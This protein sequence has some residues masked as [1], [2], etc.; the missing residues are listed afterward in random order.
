MQIHTVDEH[1]EPPPG[2]DYAQIKVRFLISMTQKLD[3]L[4]APDDVQALKG[5]LQ[6][7]QASQGQTGDSSEPH[8]LLKPL[9][10]RQIEGTL[11]WIL[12]ANWH[13]WWERDLIAHMH[14]LTGGNT[15]AVQYVLA[16]WWEKVIENGEGSVLS[17]TELTEKR[18]FLQECLQSPEPSISDL[19]VKLWNVYK[20]PLKDYPRAISYLKALAFDQDHLLKEP[21]ESISKGTWIQRLVGQ[22][23]D[24]EIVQLLEQA[25]LIESGNADEHFHFS[26]PLFCIPLFQ[27]GQ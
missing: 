3:A 16:C 20:A 27:E 9:T 13:P 10:S 23:Y 6:E 5:A 17:K 15:K 14:S 25:A 26:I 12:P 24:D 7:C 22:Q 11:R 1:S 4:F 2:T 8:F 19:L 21:A 18:K